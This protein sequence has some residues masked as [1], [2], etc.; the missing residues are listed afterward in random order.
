MQNMNG[1]LI[2]AYNEESFIKNTIQEVSNL[3]DLIIVVNDCS[4]DNTKLVIKEMNLD[5]VKIINNPKNFG[6]GKS[7][8]IGLKAFLDTDVKHIVKI[9]GDGQFKIKDITTLDDL[10][11]QKYDFVKGDRFWENGIEGNIPTIRYIGN[12]FATL[13]IKISTGNWKINDPLNGLFL[14]SKKSI[15][16]FTLPKLFY[17]YGYPFYLNVHMNSMIINKNYKNAQIKN[18][19]K[20][21]HEKSRLRPSV[22]F[23]K[24]LYFSLRSFTK[25][26][27]IKFKYSDLQISAILDTLFLLFTSFT[28]YSAIRLLLINLDYIKGSKASWLFLTILMFFTGLFSFGYSQDYERKIYEDKFTVL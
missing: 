22:M 9:D 1:C 8:E 6:A 25:K 26:I 2:L 17:K 19:I 10:G 20:Y 14:F 21:R 16:F 15:E 23:V 5:N 24:L 28:L 11:K 4:T 27:F 7:M 18:T 3:F 12:A 13:L